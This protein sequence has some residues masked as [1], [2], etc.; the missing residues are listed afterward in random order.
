MTTEGRS[1]HRL[2]VGVAET[3]SMQFLLDGAPADPGA[4][5]IGIVDAAGGVVVA[6][7]TPTS[8]TGTNP[9]TYALAGQQAVDVLTVTWTT[10]DLGVFR[11]EYEVL[12]RHLFTIAEARAHRPIGADSAG[13]LADADKYPQAAIEEARGAILDAWDA[14]IL[15]YALVPRY[16]RVVLDGCEAWDRGQRLPLLRADM[17]PAQRVR[18]LR[19]IETRAAGSSDWVAMEPAE[20]ALVQVTDDGDLYLEAGGRWPYGLR[21]VRVAFEHGLDQPP[22][23]AKRAALVLLGYVLVPTNLSS[24]ALQQ[25]TQFGTVNLAT[26]GRYGDWYGIPAVDSVLDR[27]CRRVPG[28]G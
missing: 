28:V 19:S 5:T 25:S 21:N 24:R 3:L 27:L 6:A 20:L 23:E 14:D 2:Q 12:G 4:T 7:G 10:T 17:R 22:G 18:G 11:E 1:W 8:G 26:A 9:R 13:T 15:G 16:E